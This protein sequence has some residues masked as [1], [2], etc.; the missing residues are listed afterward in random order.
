MRMLS[1]AIIAALGVSAPA[2]AEKSAE[3]SF[4][5]EG[6]TYVYRTEAKSDGKVISGRSFPGGQAFRLVVGKKMVRGVS[7]GSPVAFNLAEVKPM[8]RNAQVS[9]AD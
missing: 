7:G 2:F 9:S 5:H 4:Q 6:T 8:V 3:K 1:I